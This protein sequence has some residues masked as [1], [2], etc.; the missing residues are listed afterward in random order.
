LLGSPGVERMAA[1][2][3]SI[4]AIV[5]GAPRCARALLLRADSRC[6]AP[7]PL[8]RLIS[9]W[10]QGS[11]RPATLHRVKTVP[12]AWTIGQLAVAPRLMPGIKTLRVN[13]C[14]TVPCRDAFPPECRSSASRAFRW[15]LARGRRPV[16]GGPC[17]AQSGMAVRFGNRGDLLC[18]QG[19]PRPCTHRSGWSEVNSGCP[20]Q[21]WEK[22]E[23]LSSRRSPVAIRRVHRVRPE[24]WT[25]SSRRKE[26][27]PSGIG[28]STH[29]PDCTPS[30]PRH[31]LA[32]ASDG[33][34]GDP[35]P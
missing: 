16:R 8:P 7:T 21:V 28:S 15:K 10:V 12:Q 3:I 34:P 29:H 2:A 14:R 35:A 30:T 32:K 11:R 25:Q 22:R 24:G 20:G 6:S 13:P 18:L 9:V 23:P 33:R 26:I 31:V 4:R 17:G 19:C 5:W 27:R 1:L